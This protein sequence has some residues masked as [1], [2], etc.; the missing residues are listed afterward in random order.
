M[1]AYLGRIGGAALGSLAGLPGAV[2]GL[3][4]G[5]LVDQ[6]RAEGALG[7][8]LDRFIGR[9]D[10]ERRQ[11]A[12]RLFMVVLLVVYIRPEEDDRSSSPVVARVPRE[13]GDPRRCAAVFAHAR[14]CRERIDPACLAREVERLFPDTAGGA[15][16]LLDVLVAVVIGE[17]D[18]PLDTD[19]AARFRR[20]SALLP[21]SSGARERLDRYLTALDPHSCRVLGVTGTAGREQVRRAYRRLAADLHPDTAGVL[22]QEQQL[23]LREAFL[24]VRGAYDTLMAQLE[25][26]ESGAPAE[27][28]ATPPR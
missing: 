11:S 5:W 25:E 18:H 14:R 20:V 21:V 2:F 9:P 13:L 24:R 12:A 17:E 7:Y 16:R 6:Y 22:E 1:R 4:A 3:L 8:H 27:E 15:D 26:R 23:E 10:L 28:A 19:T